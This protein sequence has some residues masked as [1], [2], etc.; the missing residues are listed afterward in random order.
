MQMGGLYADTVDS[1]SIYFT[2]V[3]ISYVD[4]IVQLICIIGNENYAK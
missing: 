2:G 4:C 3:E 1:S